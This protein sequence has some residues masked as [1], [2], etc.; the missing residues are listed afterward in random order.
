MTRH[1]SV[2][3]A[4]VVLSGLSLPVA[5]AEPVVPPALADWKAWVLEGQEAQLC[6]LEQ[7]NSGSRRCRWPS[8]LELTLSASGGSFTQV[9][10]FSAPGELRLPGGGEH[11][12]QDVLLDGRPAAVFPRGED[13]AIEVPAGRHTVSGSFLWDRLPEVL[14]VPAQT[15]LLSLSVEGK[16]IPFPKREA[17]GR[18]FLQQQQEESRAEDRLEVLVHRK[19]TDEVPLR[20][21]TRLEVRVSGKNREVLLGPVVLQDG[22]PTGLSAPLPARIEA[23][24]K[25]RMQVRPG[26]WTITVESRQPDL[27]ESL[28][29]PKLPAPWPAEEIWVFEARRDLRVVEV[30]DAPAVDPQQTRLPQEWKGLPAYGLQAGAKLTLKEERRGDVDPAPDQLELERQWWLDFDGQGVTVQDRIT[31]VMHSGWRLTMQAPTELGRVVVDGREQ[32]ITRLGEGQPSGVEVRRRQ[33]QVIADSRLETPA[34][35]MPAVGWN[36]DFQRVSGQ[37]HLPPGWRL[38]HVSGVDSTSPDDS[39]WIESWTL[40][41]LFLVLVLTLALGKLFGWRWGAVALVTLTL[42]LPDEGPVWVWAFVLTFEALWRAL[43]GGWLRKTAWS[44]RGLS[45]LVL[46]VWTI[47]FMVMQVR[48]GMYPMLERSWSTIDGGYGGGGY[49]FDLPT[50]GAAA[51]MAGKGAM[52]PPT[53]AWDEYDGR[54]EGGD[55]AGELI[56]LEEMTSEDV[57]N[58]A[59]QAQQLEQTFERKK[60]RRSWG[61]SSRSYDKAASLSYQVDPN[62][63]VQTGPGLPR[64]QWEDVRLTWSGPVAKEQE[65]KLSLLSPT[66]NLLLAL[67]R[68]ALLGVLVLCV[69][70]AFRPAGFKDLGA[71]GA[72]AAL[73]LGLLLL[74]AAARAELPSPQLLGELQQ[75]LLQAPRCAPTCAS[76][77]RMQL[78]A[79]PAALTLRLEV[80]A[81]ADTAVP[82]PGDARHWLP[83]R[84][85]LDGSDAEGLARGADGKLWLLLPAGKHQVLATGPLPARETVQLPLGLRPLHVSERVQGW[86]LDGLHEDGVADDSLQLSRIRGQGEGSGE[87]QAGTLP[88]FVRIE[89][90]LHLGLDWTVDTTFTRLTPADSAVVVAVPLLEGESPTTDGL[91]TEEGKVLV[92]LSPGTSH[93]EWQSVLEPRDALKLVAA[94][95]TEWIE[96]WRMDASPVWHVEAEGIPPIHTQAD[97]PVREWRPWPGEAVGLTVVRPAAAE[98]Q[99][100]TID[101]SKLTISPGRRV[102]DATL[103][104]SIRAS[105][106]EPHTLTL[107]EGSQLQS[108][109]IDGTEQPLRAKEREVTLPLRPGAQQIKL[110]WR[111]TRPASFVYETSPVDLGTPSVNAALTVKPPEGRWILFAWGSVAGPAVLFWSLLIVL[112]LASGVLDRVTLTPLRVHHWALLG[113]GFTQSSV[114]VGAFVAGFFLFVGWRG[115]KTDLSRNWFNLRQLLLVGWAGVV[116]IVLVVAVSQGLLGEP[117]MQISGNG[118]DRYALHWFVD[119]AEPVLTSATIWSVPRIVYTLL[120]LAWA[121]WLAVALLGWVRWI[122]EC[123]KAD[124]LWRSPP[125]KEKPAGKEAPTE[126]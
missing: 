28:G 102:T 44:L 100:F 26:T 65:L 1:L 116:A 12:A 22:I 69:L 68:V 80:S 61:L 29:A 23:D 39:V 19:L 59:Q 103:E 118:S 85:L 10:T 43:P 15:G 45:V 115:K 111:E 98:G 56:E 79:T 41:D 74:P 54:A 16:A 7:G 120:M 96:V 13:L 64:W 5:A 124:G 32:L 89:R 95:T 8:S 101:H 24:G 42:I 35:R 90:H 27:V 33:M 2:V 78:D 60:G 91:R 109:Y 76:F 117:D 75:R 88:A 122:W 57:G 125:K 119:R 110:E 82:L 38:F 18:V 94:E 58:L 17:D 48:T 51:P 107:P 21:T 73:L 3:S 105:R 55:M 66:L 4:L 47:A 123:F 37:L 77:N 11:P 114:W 46:V 97:V 86:T 53:E 81:A 34:A 49:T 30:Q 20:V 31:G 108:V 67:L 63:V 83:S 121:L 14:Q 104:L 106:G 71:G 99:R 25:L 70:G 113:I 92:N 72:A 112:L 126:P 50:I 93:F 6:P 52:E 36:H 84:V 40:L 87:L 62:S 9:W